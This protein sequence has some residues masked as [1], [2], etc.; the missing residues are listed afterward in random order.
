M[1]GLA[2]VNVDSGFVIKTTINKVS[3]EV[4]IFVVRSILAW[5]QDVVDITKIGVFKDFYRERKEID[6]VLGKGMRR[7]KVVGVRAMMT[8]VVRVDFFA[9]SK[10]DVD[11]ASE[12]RLGCVDGEA[13]LVKDAADG[14]VLKSGEVVK[15]VLKVADG[16]DGILKVVLGLDDGV[17]YRLLTT[18]VDV[19]AEVRGG[20]RH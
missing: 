3:G 20:D 10:G 7:W 14:R 13:D 17:D 4:E 11:G 6:S 5:V 12:L 19:V 15:G 8:D 9:V 18:D 2:G 16:G 1:L